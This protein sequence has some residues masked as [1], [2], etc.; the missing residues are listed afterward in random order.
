MDLLGV[1]DLLDTHFTEDFD[2]QGSRTVLGH[3]RVSWDN[4]DLSCMVS[5]LPSIG[6]DADDLLG[7]SQRIIVKDR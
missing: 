2:C 5:F 4:S 6:L 7:K 1:P 3:S